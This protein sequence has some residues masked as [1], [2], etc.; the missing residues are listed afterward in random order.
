[1]GLENLPTVP[2]RMVYCPIFKKKIPD[3]L[4]WEIANIGNDS[5]VVH[6]EER[7]PCGWEAA[8]EICDSCPEGLAM[9]E[10]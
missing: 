3:G 4:C 10:A 5:I 2:D 9:D 1:M 7:P 8:S 6:P